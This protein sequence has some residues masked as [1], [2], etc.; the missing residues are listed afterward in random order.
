M[1]KCIFGK[2]LV[3]CKEAIGCR[4]YCLMTTFKKKRPIVKEK[5][6]IIL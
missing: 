2:K 1:S 5:L 4:T 6:L 3:L